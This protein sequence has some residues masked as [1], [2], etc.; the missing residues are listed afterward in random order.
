MGCEEIF[1][2]FVFVRVHSWLNHG[3]APQTVSIRQVGT[4][5][6]GHLG[7][8]TALSRAQSWRERFRSLEVEILRPRYVSLSEWRRPAC[9][10]SRRLYRHGYHR[11]LQAHAWIQCL[12][13]DGVGRIWSPC[14]AIRDQ[15]RPAPG[16]HHAR[17]CGQLQEPAQANWFFLRLAA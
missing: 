1:C 2:E 16:N 15:K 9:W 3:R 11:P 13:S 4:K 8:A 7:R 6:A 10:P 12:A 17:K 5:M 14:G